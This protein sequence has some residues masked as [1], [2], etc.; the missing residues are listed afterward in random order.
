M[1]DILGV[2][3]ISLADA[4]LFSESDHVNNSLIK[5]IKSMAN[6]GVT[7]LEDDAFS[8]FVRFSK[9][10]FFFCQS[11]SSKSL[12]LSNDFK[13]LFWTLCFKAVMVSDTYSANIYSDQ[14]ENIFNCSNVD[15]F[16]VLYR[17]LIGKMEHSTKVF[18][19]EA[20]LINEI[21]LSEKYHNTFNFI[22]HDN[23]LTSRELN[24]IQHAASQIKTC[25]IKLVDL[26]H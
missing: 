8:D 20:F 22:V 12:Y 6:N 5:V 23:N 10:N 16:E 13:K 21:A 26:S 4:E 17:T 7:N 1:V 25:G 15:G 9:L 18:S 24:C 11:I 3:I 2:E 14:I 19:D